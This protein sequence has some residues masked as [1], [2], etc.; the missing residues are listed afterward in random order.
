MSLV[1]FRTP[2]LRELVGLIW[3]ITCRTTVTSYFTANGRAVTAPFVGNLALTF[4]CYKQGAYLVSLCLG[5]LSVSHRCFTLVGKAN[6]GIG[7]GPPSSIRLYQN[8]AVII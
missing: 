7:N 2:L 1:H 8:A 4:P 6:K 5:Q 3:L